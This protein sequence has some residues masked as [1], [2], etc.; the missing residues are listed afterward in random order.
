MNKYIYAGPVKEF[1]KVI[2]NNWYGETMADSETKA[3]NNLAYQFKKQ[4]KRA[5]RTKIT[6]AGKII[7]VRG[8]EGN[9]D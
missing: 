3:R 9:D 6:L 5:I 8:K 1:D 2:D 7:V 4:H